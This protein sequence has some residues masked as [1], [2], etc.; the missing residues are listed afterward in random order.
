MVINDLP[1]GSLVRLGRYSYI[2]RTDDIV[3]IDW[4]KVSKENDFISV[5]V[6]FGM[7]FDE[8]EDWS[9]NSNYRLSNIRQFINS[10]NHYWYQPTHENDTY[11]RQFRFDSYIR[12]DPM[13]YSGLLYH[14]TESELA[15]IYRQDGD[16]LRLPYKQ[17]IE[18]GF[19]YFKRHGKRARP[20][21]E[22]GFLERG[23][24]DRSVYSSYFTINRENGALLEMT[25]AGGFSP[26]PPNR[27]SGIRPVC[28]LSP[29][30]TVQE[31]DGVYNPILKEVHPG[32]YYN[33]TQSLDWLLEL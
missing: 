11:P 16:Y 15:A 26:V 28:K 31:R 18:G 10:E 6:L 30:I 12:V 8:M 9:Y 14:F 27:V 22:F 19:P 33:L 2:H 13:K 21:L 5:N 7:K 3:P 24:R 17:E 23:Y 25:R 20:T 29:E 4:I 1:V 32:T